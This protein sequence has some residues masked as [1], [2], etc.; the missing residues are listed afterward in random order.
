MQCSASYP[1]LNKSLERRP[2]LSPLSISQLALIFF[3][4]LTLLLGGVAASMLHEMRSVDLQIKSTH[5]NLAARELTEAV[6]TTLGEVEAI[7][8]RV[9]AWDEVK[10]QFSRPEY[11]A[12][13]RNGR[14]LN[15]GVLPETLEG[16]DL[17]DRFGRSLS[18]AGAHDMP[19]TI[20]AAD[21]REAVVQVRNRPHIFYFLP[22]W[23]DANHRH[24]LGFAGLKLNFFEELKRLGKYRYTNLEQL[25]LDGTPRFSLAESIKHLRFQPVVNPE[26]LA[27]K[28]VL[29]ESLYRIALVVAIASVLA[30]LFLISLMAKPLTRLTRHIKSIREERGKALSEAYSGLIP[31]AEIE[32]VRLSLN[33]YQRRLDELHLRLES[34]NEELWALAYRDPLTGVFNRR[35]FEEDW[36]KLVSFAT[37]Q[38]AYVW[39]L[40]FDC[41]HFKA[42]NDTYGHEVGDQV[43]Q[44]IAAALSTALRSGDRLYR[45]GGDEFATFLFD[46]DMVYASRIAERCSGRVGMHDFGAFGVN[47]P[48]RISI[49]LA[50]AQGLDPAA[51]ARLP[52]QADLAMYHAKRPGQCK[53]VVYTDEMGTDDYVL[54]SSFETAAIYDAIGDAR[55]LEM[56]YQP[57]VELSSGDIGYYEALVRVKWRDTLIPPA[58]IFPLVEARRL[59]VDFDLAVFQRIKSDL[60]TGLLPQ[61]S[62]VSINVSGPAIVSALAMQRLEMLQPF[63]LR[64]KIVIEITETALITK[65]RQASENIEKLRAMGFMIALDDF[66]SGY[67]SLR[68]LANMPVDLVKFDIALIRSLHENDRQSNI[69]RNLAVLIRNA[70]YT[71]VAEGIEST[72]TLEIIKELGFT[73][74]QGFALGRPQPLHYQSVRAPAQI[75]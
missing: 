52:R 42:I 45:L 47:E 10:Q 35:A 2:F 41:D 3:V 62:G 1:V 46:K 12:Y 57:I 21:T 13:W 36:S 28:N 53:T 16:F 56:H 50:H 33:D 61:G 49:G 8:E 26:M 69:V 67:S 66:G 63:L 20:A 59:E 14:A 11:Y 44:G 38:R 15:A 72:E 30:Y 22:I 6:A 5:R 75:R 60:E 9:A 4:V 64:F 70:G 51:L 48:V 32:D 7:G 25:T 23:E 31:I 74:G 71:L 73:F 58:K 27:L 19:T 40:L 55:L 43:L 54:V 17:Y 65:L 18:A 39:L 29:V 24:L 37:G 68:Y 34:K